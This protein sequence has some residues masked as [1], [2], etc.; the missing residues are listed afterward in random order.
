MS[1]SG[2][3][4]PAGAYMAGKYRQA[5]ERK[6]RLLNAINRIAQI[7]YEKGTR[8]SD[9]A[10]RQRV[11]ALTG[12]VDRQ[13][14]MIRMFSAGKGGD[15]AAFRDIL[16]FFEECYLERF[17]LRELLDEVRKEIANQDKIDRDYG[18]NHPDADHARKL[19][20]FRQ[21]LGRELQECEKVLLHQA[22]PLLRAFLTE[23]ND[24]L[25]YHLLD[26]RIGR[27]ITSDDVFARSGPVY[28]EFKKSLAW[29][30]GLYI[31]LSRLPLTDEEIIET[32]NRT[33]QQAGFRN[34][35]LRSR[36]INPGIYTEIMMEV[37]A[38]GNLRQLVKRYS[39]TSRS[40]LDAIRSADKKIESVATSKEIMKVL[41]DLIY[42]EE[43]KNPQRPTGAA[44]TSGLAKNES[45]RYLFHAPG[46][47]DI[48]LKFVSEYMRDS[49]IFIIDWLGKELQKTPGSV[50]LLGPVAEC[51]P[52]I[53]TFIT[54]YKLALD[55][56]ADMSNQAGSG[57]R[58]KHFISK[59]VARGLIQ[60]V[61]DNCNAI[62]HSLIDASYGIMNS[63]LD[64]AEVLK[65]QIEI[66]K[67]SCQASHNKINKGLSEIESV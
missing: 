9:E 67:D 66:I 46:T 55:T 51:I 3:G 35:I 4:I 10:I 28:Q 48:S 36:N 41:E 64:R 38:E 15:T 13:Y 8:K 40:A 7:S 20:I 52:L 27:L 22:D 2:T 61:R 25:L 33:L 6:D 1:T 26:E 58:E 24:I 32:I 59:Q 54:Y 21:D 34:P 62:R 65:K 11:A 43:I 60:S 12:E 39:D 23:V 30:A 17:V 56:A 31:K 19:N 14:R 16:E 63:T 37:I 44:E 49:L 18:D 53:K 29:Y 45:G 5:E 57:S 50:S 47:F 42:L